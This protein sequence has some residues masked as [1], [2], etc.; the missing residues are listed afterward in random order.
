MKKPRR[1]ATLCVAGI[2]ALSGACKKEP[3]APAAVESPTSEPEQMQEAI[4]LAK[5]VETYALNHFHGDVYR[6]DDRTEYTIK[7]K[8]GDHQRTIKFTDRI[9]LHNYGVEDRLHIHDRTSEINFAAC[10]ADVGLDGFQDEL[11]SDE[12][13]LLHP[14]QTSGFSHDFRD[15]TFDD[16]DVPR[17]NQ[18]YRNILEGA[19]KTIR[20]WTC[21]PPY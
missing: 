1:L 17:V 14:T 6:T 2:L 12:Y 16:L 21:V 3:S 4:D 15:T 20:F 8:R 18:A 5:H 7:C 10:F 19:E 9:P 11:L 13:A